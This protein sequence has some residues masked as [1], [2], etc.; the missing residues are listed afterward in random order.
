MNQTE[1][2]HEL[3]SLIN[4]S[5]HGN[6]R[7]KATLDLAF[8]LRNNSAAEARRLLEEISTLIEASSDA[9]LIA[10]YHHTQ[11]IVAA[12]SF[13]YDI[14]LQELFTGLEAFRSLS[15]KEGEAR[16]LRWIA[17]TYRNVGMLVTALEY[18]QQARSI[19]EEQ[20]FINLL[21][22]CHTI[23]GDCHFLLKNFSEAAQTHTFSQKIAQ[24][25]QDAVLESQSLWSLGRV[26]ELLE[27]FEEAQ[28]YFLASY[29]LRKQEGDGLG[30]GTSQFGM[31]SVFERQGRPDEA[32]KIYL[33]LLHGFRESRYAPAQTEVFILLGIVRLYLNSSKPKRAEPYLKIALDIAQSIATRG[34][35]LA[36]VYFEM[37]NFLKKSGLFE[38]ALVYFE[39]YHKFSQE[40]SQREAQQT[41]QF[42]RQAYEF[43][44]ARQQN[45]LYRLRN[46]ELAAANRQ[47]ERLLLNVLP[48][49]IAHRMKSGETMIAEY[50][51]D[52]TVLFADIVGFTELAAEQS[53]TDL[54]TLLNRIFSAFD[55]FSEQYN[56]EKIKTIGDAY[57]IV[58]GVPEA[59]PHHADA[60]AQMA[61]EMLDTM[62]LLSKSL[63]RELDIRIGIHTGAVVAGVIGQK[64]FSYDL[65]GDTVNTASRMESHGEAGRIHVSE[66]VYHALREQ[67]SFKERGFIDIKGKGRMKTYFLLGKKH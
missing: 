61:L 37:S 19:A 53:P 10:E 63:G 38:E 52:V 31:A 24:E 32:L 9:L 2:I 23:I 66:T 59:S 44:K 60:V 39:Q 47:N 15:N 42:F 51:N 14:S 13:Q 11:G 54:V 1:R 4:T 34:S 45:E 43:E 67:F 30:M 56:L 12:C 57:M 65:W 62:R 50:F 17:I 3:Q 26:H 46:E 29:E 5:P 40:L 22:Y 55:I 48:E 21:G 33:R 28:K 16:S 20:G 58:G 41:S 7:L 49:A 27:E 18:A 36:S 8:E 25:T 35:V 64:K 6:I